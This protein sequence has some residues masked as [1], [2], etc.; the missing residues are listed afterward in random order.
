MDKTT[1]RGTAIAG[2]IAGGLSKTADAGEVAYNRKVLWFFNRQVRVSLWQSKLT[3]PLN[4]RDLVMPG[5]PGRVLSSEG[6]MFQAGGKTWHRGTTSLQMPAGKRTITHLQELSAPANH[7]Y[8][9]RSLPD[10][11]AVGLATG[12]LD[13][14]NMPGYVGRISKTEVLCPAWMQAKQ[15]LIKS[16][17][18][19][20]PEEA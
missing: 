17:L 10:E 14:Q 1:E 20:P 7:Y 5:G 4:R 16:R 11:Q 19:W 15:L 12:R 8:F 2:N 9:D 13:P 3:G 18:H 6:V